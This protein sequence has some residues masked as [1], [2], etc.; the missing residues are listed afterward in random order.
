[1]Q[2]TNLKYLQVKRPKILKVPMSNALTAPPPVSSE[3]N[4]SNEGNGKQS[5]PQPVSSYHDFSI[6]FL[7]FF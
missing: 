7:I 5:Q 6:L 2:K 4:V 3:P 1:M